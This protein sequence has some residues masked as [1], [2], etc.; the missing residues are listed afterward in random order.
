MYIK[1]SITNRRFIHE[2][3]IEQN[4]RRLFYDALLDSGTEIEVKGKGEI[5]LG[6]LEILEKEQVDEIG[7]IIY[8]ESWKDT[9]QNK[10]YPHSFRIIAQIPSS[11]FQSLLNLPEMNYDFYFAMEVNDEGSFS[12]GWAPDGRAI[13]WD[14][15]TNITEK[16]MSSEISILPKDF[17]K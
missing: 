6:I 5:I 16:I 1:F 12:Y 3:S 10:N 11:T 17:L 2:I 13:D 7:K 14:V 8:E 15:N 9:E 4:R